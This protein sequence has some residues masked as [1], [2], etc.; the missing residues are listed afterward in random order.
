MSFVIIVTAWASMSQV[1]LPHRYVTRAECNRSAV[2]LAKAHD[3][4]TN[5]LFSWR[6][7]PQEAAK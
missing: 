3:T 1:T 5:A 6:C 4:Q 7:V 2:G